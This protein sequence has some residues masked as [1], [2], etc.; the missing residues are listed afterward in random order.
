MAGQTY[1]VWLQQPE[2]DGMPNGPPWAH[3]QNSN[4]I[5]S[6]VGA[7]MDDQVAKMR[8]AAKLRGPDYCASVSALDALLEHGKDRLLPRGSVSTPGATDEALTAYAARLDQAWTTWA[9]AGMPLGLLTQLK[10]A[11]FPATQTYLVNH[12]GKI[13]VLDGGGNLTISYAGACSNRM[14]LLG[15]IPSPLLNGFTLDARDQFYS[16]FMI[17]FSTTVTGLANTDGNSA[18]ACL[19][20]TVQRWRSGGAIYEGASMITSGNPLLGWPAGRLLGS[21]GAATLGSLGTAI[22]I[23][24]GITTE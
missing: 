15:A 17:I 5:W 22:F 20:Q 18:K 23:D 12:I 19:N 6:A 7:V 3:G 10:V 21:L 1:Q 24:P 11:G 16:H 14:D 4:R 9:Q 8:A 13:Y 2:H